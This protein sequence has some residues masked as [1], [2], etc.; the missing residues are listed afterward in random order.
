MRELKTRDEVS[1]S[2]AA[3]LRK[4]PKCADVEVSVQYEL[5]EPD[6]DGCNWSEDLIVNAGGG[7]Y[8]EVIRRLRPIHIRARELFNVSEP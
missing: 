6:P 7:D 1:Q 4:Q 5:Q 2:I 8:D 3:E